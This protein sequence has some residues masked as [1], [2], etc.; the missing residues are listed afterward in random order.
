MPQWSARVQAGQVLARLEPLPHTENGS[1]QLQQ[2]SQVSAAQ[3]ASAEQNLALLNQQLQTLERQDQ[4]LQTATVAIAAENVDQSQSAVDAAIAQES[5]A[6]TQYD[7]FRSLLADGAVSQQQVDELEATWRS[8]Q[9]A[10]RQ[11][12]SEKTIAQVTVDALGQRTPLQGNSKDLQSQRRQLLKEIQTQTAQLDLLAL[13]HENQQTQLSQLQSRYGSALVASISAPFDGVI[14]STQQD[15]GEQVN[16]P[17]TLLSLLDCNDLWV[18][19]LVSTQQAKR[20]DTDQPVRVQLA[21]YPE[22]VVGEVDLVN[23]ISA[24]DLTKA[25]AEALLPAIPASLVGQPLARVRVK[26]PPTPAQNQSH[27]LCGV[28]QS[29]RLTFGTHSTLPT[30]ISRR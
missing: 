30:L 23:A 11:A 15:A 4:A 6:R 12:K 25:R 8:A 26:I 28:G 17:A 2:G 1:T 7:R 29:A 18:E 9:A 16:R 3:L 27:Q 22:T 5:V 24:G 21:G 19:A 10:V 14:Y 20:I 13:A